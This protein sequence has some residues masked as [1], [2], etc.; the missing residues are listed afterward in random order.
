LSFQKHPGTVSSEIIV[1]DNA[2]TDGSA[3]MV[4]DEFPEV[5][6]IEN[7]DNTGY[8]GGCNIGIKA[9]K[10][11]YLL[12]I[13]SDILALQGTLEGNVKF[14]DENPK[15]GIIGCRVLN[16]D[17]SLQ[18]TCFMYP[19][20]LN[21][22]LACSYLYKIF[23]KNKFFG[24]G[25]ISWWDR[26]DVREVDVIT[27][28]CMMIRRQALE[29]VGLM[30]EGYFM[31]AEETDW[32]YRF[33]KVGWKVIFTPD[34]E[35]IHLGGQSTKRIRGDMLVKEKL[36]VLKF[37]KKHHCW[38]Y[39]KVACLFVLMFFLFRLP[40]WFIASLVTKKEE[41][42]VKLHVCLNG[43]KRIFTAA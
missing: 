2:S 19:S 11:R 36:S 39:H 28:C 23:P 7:P 1:V 35:I 6:L 38:L 13:N 5:K 8:A 17:M 9:A 12:I 43:I 16:P 34:A 25:A 21:L 33:N 22:F 31:Y 15:A 26:N 27:G 37:I 42:K 18:P 4:K 30:D 14:A 24:R 20:M 41:A 3:Q 10:G 40:V 32:C 29:E